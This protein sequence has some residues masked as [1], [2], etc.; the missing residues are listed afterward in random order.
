MQNSVYY[1][2]CDKLSMNASVIREIDTFLFAC[3][4]IFQLFFEFFPAELENLLA[5]RSWFFNWLT[6]NHIHNSLT[7]FKLVKQVLFFNLYL[8]TRSLKLISQRLPK[9]RI[10]FYVKGLRIL[11]YK[12]FSCRVLR[13]YLNILL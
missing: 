6:I 7:V 9:T 1:I 12:L 3:H 8:E 2:I 5:D 13:M 11:S 4:L 10:D